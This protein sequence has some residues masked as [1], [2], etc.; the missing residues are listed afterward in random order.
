M[1]EPCVLGK[2]ARVQEEWNTVAATDFTHARILANETGCPP[3]ELLVMVKKT[4]GIVAARSWRSVSSA[5]DHV[6]FEGVNRC[7][8]VTF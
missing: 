5:P 7:G 1:D 8:V 2:S 6:P 3:P 4:T